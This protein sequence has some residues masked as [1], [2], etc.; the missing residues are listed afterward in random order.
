MDDISK[1]K[2]AV[3]VTRAPLPK[4]LTDQ[5]FCEALAQLED[6]R[7]RKIIR[8]RYID[9]RSQ[10][11]VAAMKHLHRGRTITPQAVRGLEGRALQ[12][13]RKYLIQECSPKRS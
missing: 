10:A 5:H 13:M 3:L 6:S 12:Q 2:I 4:G 7:L 1:L 8:L 9:G 11:E